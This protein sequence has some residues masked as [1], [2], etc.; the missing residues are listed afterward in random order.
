MKVFVTGA[1][2]F[3]GSN[4]AQQLL[5]DNHQ[6][7]TLRRAAS[8]GMP[9]LPN[10]EVVAGGLE[11][12]AD[13]NVALKGTQAAVYTFPLIFDMDTAK[14][15]TENFISAAKEQQVPLVI[16]NTT[17]E[18]PSSKTDILTLDMKVVMKELFDASGLN[19]IT[20]VPDVYID[21]VAAPWSIP[22]ILN[23]NI[24][25]YPIESGQKIPWIS[26]SD[27]GR[28]VTAAITKPA[29]AGQ[30]YPIGGNLISGEEI[31][32]AIQTKIKSP[33]NF[34]SVPV[35]DFEKQLVP[36]FGDV[37][38]KEISNLYRYVAKNHQSIISKDF[39][40]TNELLG[41][42]PQPLNEWVESVNWNVG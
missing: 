34:V 16:F 42:T 14:A 6:V 33:V 35:D 25:P 5:A 26:L 10:I 3:Q 20:L 1:T 15:Y 17:F 12:K 40:K 24:L 4:I 22:V 38:A 37:A 13:L 36:G 8:Q 23:N 9:P 11:N 31:A 30:V 19:V 27:I 18:L 28:Y 41:I 32:A 7:V 21:N 39:A 2:G 29:L